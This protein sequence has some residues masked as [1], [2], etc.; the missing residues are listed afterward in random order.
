MIAPGTDSCRWASVTDLPYVSNQEAFS[1]ILDQQGAAWARINQDVYQ[2]PDPYDTPIKQYSNQKGLIGDFFLNAHYQD[3]STHELYFGKSNGFLSLQPELTSKPTPLPT[4]LFTSLKISNQSFEHGQKL[5]GK[6]IL[7]QHIHETQALRLKRANSTF[8]LGITTLDFRP[9]VQSDY[10]FRLEGYESEWHHLPA[11][12]Q[13]ISYANLPVGTYQLRVELQNVRGHHTPPS[14]DMK[15]IIEPEIY[16]QAWFSLLLVVIILGSVYLLIK[17]R[18]TVLR[19]QNAALAEKVTLRTQEL[20]SSYENIRMLSEWGRTLTSHREPENIISSLYHQLNQLMDASSFYLGQAL[21]ETNEMKYLGYPSPLAPT[22]INRRKLTD[23]ESLSIWSY[24]H[25]RELFLSDVPREASMYLGPDHHQ[26]YQHPDSAQSLISIPLQIGQKCLGVLVVKSYQKGAFSEQNFNILSNLASYL[27]VALENAKAYQQVQEQSLARTRFY[28]NL[29]H[30]LRTPLTLIVSPLEELMKQ[31]GP[32]SQQEDLRLV[33]RH[34]HR[35]QGVLDQLL[36][37]GQLEEGVL[38]ANIQPVELNGLLRRMHEAFGLI[39]RQK[40]QRWELHIPEEEVWLPTDEGMLEK[41][42]YNLI[43]NALKYSPEQAHIGLSYE[44]N[45]TSCTLLVHDN[46]PGIPPTKQQQIFE[47]FQA[48]E[49]TGEQIESAEGRPPSIGLGL[50][51]VQKLV[52]LLDGQ[53][54]IQSDVHAGTTV[55]VHLPWSTATPPSETSWLPATPL[56]SLPPQ[57]SASEETGVLSPK[58]ESARILIAEDHPDLQAYLYR[59]LSP[60]YELCIVADGAEALSKIES[61][62]PDLILSDIMM[63]GMNGLELVER[64]KTSDAFNHLPVVLLTARA[65]DA[66]RITG[67]TYGAD[68]YLTKPFSLSLLRLK[69]KNLLTYRQNLLRRYTEE[70]PTQLRPVP[71]HPRDAA[72]LERMYDILESE[73]GNPYLNVDFLAQELG[74]S[75]TLLFNKL[76]LITGESGKTL[77]NNYKMNK[78]M[79]WLRSGKHSVAEVSMLVGYAEPKYFSQAFKRHTGQPP[80][81][82]LPPS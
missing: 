6:V 58:E 21:P 4:L 7:T 33:H 72:F 82:Y 24:H 55:R 12:K 32:A 11:G 28:N 26:R 8:T 61:F 66:D 40:S 45:D 51:F 43:S 60:H 74:M 23:L 41:I 44:R 79:E 62:D 15:L 18:T 75:R 39:A 27:A 31:K 48:V 36:E 73:L 59:S 13:A 57:R 19:R 52:S 80:S 10:R 35:M 30:E 53:V 69:L 5:R 81:S 56:P 29:S 71:A 37:L 49:E 2:L 64:I 20:Q 65:E 63:P 16:Q 47:R 42:L 1:L 25:Q 3:P 76:K 46:G 68:A 38:Q 70:A 78:A 77:L 50:A 34:A 22:Q 14:I 67:L 17:V 9:L 54:E